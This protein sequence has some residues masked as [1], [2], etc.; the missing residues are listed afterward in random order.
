MKIHQLAVMQVAGPDKSLMLVCPAARPS[1]QH[2]LPL[3]HT[4]AQPKALKHPYNEHEPR[5]RP[6]RGGLVKYLGRLRQQ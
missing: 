3:C 6:K 2:N 4:Q 5:L 1:H